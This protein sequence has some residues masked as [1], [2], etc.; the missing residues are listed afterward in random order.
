MRRIHGHPDHAGYAGSGR[1][2]SGDVW[3]GR[4]RR[5]RDRRVCPGPD[6]IDRCTIT[7]CRFGPVGVEAKAKDV[8]VP[9]KPAAKIGT[10]HRQFTL[11][12]GSLENLG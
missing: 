9:R 4:R 11:C 8:A 5:H 7:F 2:R 6:A 3:V 12:K 10:R 1:V